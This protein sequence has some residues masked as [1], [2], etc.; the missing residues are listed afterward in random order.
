MFFVQRDIQAVK[1]PRMAVG[2]CIRSD[3]CIIYIGDVKTTGHCLNLAGMKGRQ[4]G[5]GFQV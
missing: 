4:A 2:V 5:P 3:T 1:L